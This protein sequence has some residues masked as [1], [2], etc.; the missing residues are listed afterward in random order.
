MNRRTLFKTAAGLVLAA[1]SGELI[2]PERRVW[3]L[4]RT[5]VGSVE[6]KPGIW[7][8]GLFYEV[9]LRERKRYEEA[10]RVGGMQW[11]AYL[12]RGRPLGVLS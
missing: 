1:G 7:I 3:A 11:V 5:M 4:D 6:V 10:V 2:L 9:Y 8:D 12:E